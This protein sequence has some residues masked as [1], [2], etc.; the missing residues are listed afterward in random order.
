MK[1]IEQTTLSELINDLSQYD[2]SFV[3]YTDTTNN[4]DSGSVVYLYE[5]DE[6]EDVQIL[7]GGNHYFLEIGL[8]ADVIETWNDWT[9]HQ[10]NNT[11]D[12]CNAV[13][14]YAANDAYMSAD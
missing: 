4:I 14:Y 3:V 11:D 6:E 10:R 13:I 12:L 5:F 9:D 8:I 2:E 1:L 7:A